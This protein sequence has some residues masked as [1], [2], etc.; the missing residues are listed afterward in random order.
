MAARA[1]AKGGEGEGKG[2]AAV[3]VGMSMAMAVT[4][5][6]AQ[7]GHDGGSGWPARAVEGSAQ[8][9]AVEGGGTG[10]CREAARAAAATCL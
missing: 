10:S 5:A 1:A 3:A 6:A 2:I 4:M 9:V 7:I 8:R